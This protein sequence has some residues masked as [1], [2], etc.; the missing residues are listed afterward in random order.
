MKKLLFILVVLVALTSCADEKTFYFKNGKEITEREFNDHAFMSIVSKDT[1]T[2][3]TVEPYGWADSD[4]LKDKNVVYKVCV[5][6]IVWDVIGFESV[7]IP[8]WLTGWQLYEPIK[9]K[10]NELKE[11]KTE[12]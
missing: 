3:Y 8:V 7:I 11:C 12:E 5:G 4:E 6:N 2:T 10:K 1:F 9:L